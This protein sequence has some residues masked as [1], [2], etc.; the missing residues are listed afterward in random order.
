MQLETER[1]IPRNPFINAGT[2]AVADRL[3]SQGDAWVDLLALCLPCKSGVGGGI[4]AVVP[5]GLSLCV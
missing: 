4:M 3:L 2:I 5:D 1:G